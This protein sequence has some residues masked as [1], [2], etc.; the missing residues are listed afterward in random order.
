MTKNN[1]TEKIG[2]YSI[3]ELDEYG[4]PQGFKS[5]HPMKVWHYM[6]DS[7]KLNYSKAYKSTYEPP[8]LEDLEYGNYIQ[9]M[10]NLGGMDYESM[11]NGEILSFIKNPV[12]VEKGDD[13]RINDDP[14]PYGFD[15]DNFWPGPFDADHI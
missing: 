15:D 12:V 13:D 3:G 5:K 6:T 11:C 1:Q 2:S 8:S 9:S 14:D 7:E 4:V 10:I